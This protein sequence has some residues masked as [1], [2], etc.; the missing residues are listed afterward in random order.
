MP[1]IIPWMYFK[2]LRIFAT[3]LHRPLALLGAPLHKVNC[4]AYLLHI[5][6]VKLNPA[7]ILRQIIS[8]R[9]NRQITL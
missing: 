4:R 5:D 9:L 7:A 3:R 2:W 6:P 1:L 8:E